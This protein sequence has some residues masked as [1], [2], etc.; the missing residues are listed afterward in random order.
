MGILFL[1]HWTKTLQYGRIQK[2]I[3]RRFW[4][5]LNKLLNYFH[6]FINTLKSRKTNFQKKVFISLR[7]MCLQSSPFLSLVTSKQNRRLCL[8]WFSV[9]YSE[10]CKQ[11]TLECKK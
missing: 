5:I 6:L 10:I 9:L 2:H 3:K 7:L 11:L 4:R 1:F 8:G